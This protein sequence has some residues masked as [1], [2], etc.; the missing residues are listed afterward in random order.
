MTYGLCF[1]VSIQVFSKMLLL[2]QSACSHAVWCEDAAVFFESLLGDPHLV[3][4]LQRGDCR[5]T[6]PAGDVSVGW[7]HQC[8][9]HIL[10][11]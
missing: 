3:E 10:R 1:L 4:R 6:T 8:Y 7:R 2:C 9:L 5:R 11:E